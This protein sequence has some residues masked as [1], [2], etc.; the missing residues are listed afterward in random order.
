MTRSPTSSLSRKTLR[1]TMW[2]FYLIFDK[3]GAVNDPYCDGDGCS[4][5]CTFTNGLQSALEVLLETEV[6]A[7]FI[8]ES[9]VDGVF[10][11]LLDQPLEGSGEINLKELLPIAGARGN[12]TGF[13]AT[14]NEDNP[15]V[16][17]A[18]GNRALDFTV[19]V[20]FDGAP[21]RF[22]LR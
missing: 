13:L 1:S 3:K 2:I 16:I 12:P 7:S 9:L 6:L 4:A 20:G 21:A 18:G 15:K 22:A 8:G 14:A 19:D 11:D 10:G 5:W 17:S